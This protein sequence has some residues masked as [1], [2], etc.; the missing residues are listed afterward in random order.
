MKRIDTPGITVGATLGCGFAIQQ[1]HRV[2]VASEQVCGKSTRY[3]G[4]DNR[5][6]FRHDI[7]LQSLPHSCNGIESQCEGSRLMAHGLPVCIAWNPVNLV[8]I[9]GE[10]VQGITLG[11]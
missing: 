8:D 5:D 2:T 10:C 1:Y 7:R 3:P 6:F 11:Q 4:S 9:L